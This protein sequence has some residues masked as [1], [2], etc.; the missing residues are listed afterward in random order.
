MCLDR[1]FFLEVLS[2]VVALFWQI[3]KGGKWQVIWCLRRPQIIHDVGSLCMST[4]W[5]F[6]FFLVKRT[7]TQE[8]QV[9]ETSGK[10][11]QG[12]LDQHALLNHQAVLHVTLHPLPLHLLPIII[13]LLTLLLILLLFLLFNLKFNE[14]WKASRSPLLS[15]RELASSSPGSKLLAG[16]KSFTSYKIVTGIIIF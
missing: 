10:R 11:D 14:A 15:C 2:T 16:F 5:L 8:L 6:N 4:M 13:I 12:V 9:K 7:L 1:L 3:W